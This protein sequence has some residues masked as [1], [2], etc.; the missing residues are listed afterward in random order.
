ML[1]ITFIFYHPPSEFWLLFNRNIYLIPM[2]TIFKSILIC[3]AILSFNQAANAT[4][5]IILHD[6]QDMVANDGND[7]ICAC[8]KGICN[9]MTGEE[10]RELG[11]NQS[12]ANPNKKAPPNSDTYFIYKNPKTALQYKR[13]MMIFNNDKRK[14]AAENEIP[15]HPCFL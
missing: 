7:V 13:G 3:S 11:Y 10:M 5:M 14:A 1:K 15:N 4:Y 2:K 9:Y 6:D 12:F 8:K